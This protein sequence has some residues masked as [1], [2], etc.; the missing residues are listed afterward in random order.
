A[1]MIKYQ[2]RVLMGKDIWNPEEYAVYFRVLE[3]EDEYFDYYRKRHAFWKMYGLGLPD[4]VLKKIYYK[5]ALKLI[6]GI[7]GS[8][9]P[10]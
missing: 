6:P 1:F 9:F 7:D 5:N 4:D 3:T 10:Q 2:D 8:A